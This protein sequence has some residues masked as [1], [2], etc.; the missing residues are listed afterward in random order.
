MNASPS[1]FGFTGVPSQDPPA[2]KTTDEKAAGK[3]TPAKVVEEEVKKEGATGDG[4]FD[5]TLFRRVDLRVGNII[6]VEEREDF[7]RTFFEKIDVGEGKPR[8]IGTGVRG[9]VAK[10]EV[11]GLVCVFANL[12]KKKIGPDFYS[13]GMVL[14]AGEGSKI[15]FLR[16]PEGKRG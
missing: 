5:E 1:P 15:E 8:D 6:S 3:D 14:C 2:A 12:K 16:P 10:E 13:E 7:D 4:T 11:K 9:V